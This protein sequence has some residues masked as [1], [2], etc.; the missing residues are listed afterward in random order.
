MPVNLNII[1][2]SN[3]HDFTYYK[4]AHRFTNIILRIIPIQNTKPDITNNHS[5]MLINGLA[6]HFNYTYVT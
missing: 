4:K 6:T 3:S 2:L 5:M 1:L